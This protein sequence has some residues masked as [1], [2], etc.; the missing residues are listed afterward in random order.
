MNRLDHAEAVAEA[1]GYEVR[2]RKIKLT[3]RLHYS[4]DLLS[5]LDPPLVERIADKITYTFQT[6]IAEWEESAQLNVPANWWEHFKDRWFKGWLRKRFPVQYKTYTA[7][8]LLPEFPT[9][10]CGHVMYVLDPR[11]YFS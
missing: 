9:D 1:I 5:R 11:G 6:Q 3:S 7:K 8:A 10:K 2:M 4:L